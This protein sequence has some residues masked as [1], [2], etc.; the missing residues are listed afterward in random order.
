MASFDQDFL[1]YIHAQNEKENYIVSPLS[2]RAALIL[3]VEGAD[4]STHAQL[5]TA[6]GFASEEEMTQWY[7]AVRES[8]DSF[9]SWVHQRYITASSDQNR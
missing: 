1:D 2:Y 9:D 6:M 4:A 7:T 5:L 3:A 8:I